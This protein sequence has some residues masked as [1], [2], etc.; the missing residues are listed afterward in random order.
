[1]KTTAIIIGVGV[2]LIVFSDGYCLETITGKCREWRALSISFYE[3]IS[4][5]LPHIIGW[6][7]TLKACSS[8]F[9]P[10]SNLRFWLPISFIENVSNKTPIFKITI[11]L[12]K[13]NEIDKIND[14]YFIFIHHH[15]SIMAHIFCKGHLSLS[16]IDCITHYFRW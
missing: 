6:W 14:R 16:V 10:F 15:S 2:I 8:S 5:W 13:I 11:S 1:M 9:L 7:Q 12:D 4:N 3:P